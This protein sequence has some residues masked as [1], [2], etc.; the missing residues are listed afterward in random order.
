MNACYFY[1]RNESNTG[2]NL[3]THAL[4]EMYGAK[5]FI[6]IGSHNKSK[7]MY[8]YPA[9]SNSCQARVGLP[10]TQ[11]TKKASWDESD[12]DL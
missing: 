10:P 11:C 2:Q 9:P 7:K 5:L 1:T 3:S 8:E 4:K 12:D 6:H